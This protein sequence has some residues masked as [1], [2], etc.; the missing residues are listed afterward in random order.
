MKI[1]AVQPDDDQ[2]L[3][4]ISYQT[5][6]ESFGPPINTE[7]DIQDYLSK[8]FT[9]EQINKEL[10]NSNSEFYFAVLETQ[11]VGYIKV[12][13]GNAQTENI[14]GNTLE[15]ERI[16]VIEG[17]RGKKIGLSLLEK[18]LVLAQ[19]KL[20]EFVWLG[21][22]KENKRAIKFYLKNS[23]VAFDEHQFVLGTSVQT[24]LMMKRKL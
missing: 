9:L 22:W 15:I 19:Q 8:H 21:V 14:A 4:D 23:F 16:Y 24:D 10:Q 20:A 6:Y 11:I 13:Y 7:E 18:A 3:L 2:T 5:F 17:L 12:N 1:I